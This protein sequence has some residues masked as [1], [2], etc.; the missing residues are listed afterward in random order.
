MAKLSKKD[1][2]R[3][4]AYNREFYQQPENRKKHLEELSEYY[5]KNREK[6]LKK[7]IKYKKEHA[8]ETKDYNTS[9][10]EKNKEKIKRRAR[11]YARK[12]ALELKKLRV[13]K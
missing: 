7:A 8:D 4:N 5:Q 3:K 13:K 1:Q 2:E 10:Y 9:Y 11:L 6:L 12:K